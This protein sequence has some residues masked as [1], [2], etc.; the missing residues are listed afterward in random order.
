MKKKKK[1]QTNKQPGQSSLGK[2]WRGDK[3]GC[4]G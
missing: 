3:G 2:P 1:K 4:I